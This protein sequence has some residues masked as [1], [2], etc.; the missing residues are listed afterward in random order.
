MGRGDAAEEI[1]FGAGLQLPPASRRTVSAAA[2]VFVQI[3]DDGKVMRWAQ[4]E[5]WIRVHT[6]IYG[7]QQCLDL[8]ER[9][10][11]TGK[12]SLGDCRYEL[13][14]SLSYMDQ[15]LRLPPAQEDG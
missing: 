14:D 4:I 5:N 8:V 9:L 7:E 12:A 1:L 10:P 6:Q 15:L 13:I 3:R 2:A 11:E